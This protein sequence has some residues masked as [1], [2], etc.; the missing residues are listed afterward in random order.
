M[1]NPSSGTLADYNSAILDGYATHVRVVFPVQNVTLTDD[2]ISAEGGITLTQ[3]LNPD[4]DLIM[5]KAVASQIVIR[6]LNNGQFTGFD[7]T[8][9]FHVDFGVDIGGTT[10]WVTVGYFTGKKPERIKR[11]EVI[12]FTAIDRMSKFDILADDF[13]STL[14]FPK[15]MGQI[16]SALYS[17]VG[18]P[19]AS[20]DG[21]L[22]IIN[23][24][25]SENPFPSGI[26]CRQILAWIVEANCC[27]AKITNDGKIRM[28]W[29]SDQTSNYSIDADKYFDISI[30]E[31]TVPVIDSVR[32][33]DTQNESNGFLYPV[34]TNDVVYQIIDNPLLLA[35]TTAQKQ[36]VINNITTRFTAIG[37]Y[38]PVTVNAIGNWM[39]ETG[40]IIEVGYDNS[41]TLN[42]PVF[43]RT[44]HWNGGGSDAY[45]CT[46][47]TERNEMTE[48]VKQQYATGG[49][50]SNKY[51]IISGIDINDNG[52]EITGNKYVKILSG[53]V[54]DLQSTNMD[55]SSFGRYILLKHTVSQKQCALG[56]GQE[57]ASAAP[58]TCN[59]DIDPDAL[60][61]RYDDTSSGTMQYHSDLFN[62]MIT[63]YEPGV[64]DI[65][66]P[67]ITGFAY[68]YDMISEV[69]TQY[70]YGNAR[71]GRL[72]SNSFY[73]NY[74]IAENI[75]GNG[76]ANNLTTSTSGKVLDARQGKALNDII[77]THFGSLGSSTTPVTALEDIP[78]NRI[79]NVVLD[80]SVSP[81]G[82]TRSHSIIKW[83]LSTT[84]YHIL[85]IDQYANKMYLF[86]NYDGTLVG[87][88]SIEPDS[89]FMISE[90]KIP[91]NS[92]M[93]NYNTPGVYTVASA[94]VAATISNIPYTSSG[95]RLEVI[96]QNSN[97]SYQRQMY[98]PSGS[99]Y[100]YTRI[101]GSSAWG[102][103][104]RLNMTAV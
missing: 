55:I 90:T 44:F 104:Y 92:N 95:G 97:S 10:N 70:P 99:V 9:E 73:T 32:I 39:V 15:T 79:G 29:F 53:G 58:I 52:V 103:W 46:G 93:D 66:L 85:A 17:Y 13:I 19:Y 83:G 94:A 71:F 16:Y 61:I 1:L 75:S 26:T 69:Q 28:T 60:A 4:T 43:S 49:Q 8:E 72:Q 36:T 88:R 18:V 25:Y 78:L 87:W 30:D 101:K 2:D 54:F 47:E 20:G 5:G 96:G 82:Y 24:S 22:N 7:W 48:S 62:G 11:A 57:V 80:S 98:Y 77:N 65:T 64:G 56:I 23:T 50:L 34:G 3:I 21:I 67:G 6:F 27:Y 42:M 41:Q 102:G 14:T 100:I 33:S 81:S 68:K 86:E 76:V 74:A 63:M 38:T 59:I 84:R 37:A 40:D 31:A 89:I 12:E 51:T 45:E 35:M 91:S